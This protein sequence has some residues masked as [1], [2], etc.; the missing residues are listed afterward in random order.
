LVIESDVARGV[1]LDSG[2]QVAADALVLATGGLSY[3]STGSTGDG[4]S[5]ATFCG[6]TITNTRPSLTSLITA[7]SWPGML[8]GLTLKNVALSAYLGK[9]RLFKQQGELLFT[10]RGLSGPLAL[11]LSALLP[12]DFRG[13]RLSIDLKPALDEPTVNARLLRE[14]QELS[15]KQLIAALER[16][17]PRSLAMVLAELADVPAQTPAHSVT[18]AQR[19]RLVQLIKDLPL[20]VQDLGGYAEAVIT[21]G[22]VKTTEI[23]PSTLESKRV[24]GLYFAG[25]MIDVDALTGGF[26]LQIAFSTGALA[27]KSAAR[28]T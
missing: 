21:R 14:F 26:N 2:E 12:D 1:L 10:H 27:G 9:K 13:A 25:E 22:G 24:R 11:T 6:H 20:T 5:M 7:E 3:P 28:G 17:A 18:H 8:S 15:R 16:L 23:N 4:L 19:T